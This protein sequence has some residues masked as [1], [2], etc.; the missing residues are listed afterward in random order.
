MR[1]KMMG[2]KQRESVFDHKNEKK[3]WKLTNDAST[4]GYAIFLKP[5][6]NGGHKFSD[7]DQA[8]VW[9]NTFIV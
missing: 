5:E 7:E 2:M 9:M 1:I 3:Q 8:E 4:M 6:L